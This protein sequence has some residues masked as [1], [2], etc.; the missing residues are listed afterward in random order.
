MAGDL[1]ITDKVIASG[2]ANF[3]YTAAFSD[4]A[5]LLADADIAAVNFE[6]SLLGAPYGSETASAPQ[7]LMKALSDAGVDL[8]QLANSFS[9]SAG[10]AGLNSTIDGVREAGMVPLGVCG[11]NA[12][13]SQN[14]GYTIMQVKGIRIAFVAFTKGMDGMALPAGSE[15]CVNVLYTDYDSTYQQV[16]TEKITAILR[17]VQNENPDLTIALLHWGSEFNNTI[18]TSQTRIRDL[19]FKNGVD[20]IIGTHSHYVQ[21][22]ELDPETGKFTAYSLGDMFGD[23]SQAGSEYSVL[24]DLEITKDTRANTAKITGYSY[25][26]IFTVAQNDAPLRV[27]RIEQAMSAYEKDFMQKVSEST[28]D[29]MKYAL[30]RIQARTAGE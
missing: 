14:G 21:K 2:G 17:R 27:V 26:P 16:D 3:D 9:I 18:S 24:L 29:A 28:Y 20:A 5:H 19:M 30:Q 25:T 11:S 4:I 6:G 13:F 22:M 8:V 1:N 12:E 10:I 23:A 15:N 7:N